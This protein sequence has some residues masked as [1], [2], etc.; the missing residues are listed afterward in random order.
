MLHLL[1]QRLRR[2][3][4]RL[5]AAPCVH[6]EEKCQENHADTERTYNGDGVTVQETGEEDGD[7]LPQGHYDGED[8]RTELADG[9]EDEELAARRAH[10]QQHGVH[11]KLGVT[12]HEGHRLEE[13]ALL[14]QRADGEE[15]GEQVDS[16]HHLH[17]GHLVLEQVVLPV[18]G[19]AVEHDVA[20][21]DDDPAER[22]DGGRVLTGRAGQQEHADAHRDQHGGQVLPVLVTL[23]GDELPHEHDRNDLGGLGQDLGGEADVLQGLVLTPAAHDVGER[24][25]GVL[26]HG[27]SVARLLEQEAP[28]ARHGQGQDA[29]HEDQ[30]L[31]VLEFLSLVLGSRGSIGTGHHPLLQ[32]APCQVGSLGRR[33]WRFQGENFST[34]T[35]CRDQN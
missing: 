3:P 25:E 10:G 18:G 17:R 2:P 27:R 15:A 30:E 21:E 9:V 16:E 6:P 13:G 26:V 12:R 28:D 35:E 4:T 19:E 1:C 11:G 20:H 34:R 22:G 14:Q 24:G 33:G 31:G 29:V 8:G 32:D 23:A 5:H 7:G